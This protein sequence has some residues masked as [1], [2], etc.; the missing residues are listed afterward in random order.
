MNLGVFKALYLHVR[1]D[2]RLLQFGVSFKKFVNV[3]SLK[4]LPLV[5]LY[6]FI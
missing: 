4:A 5:P 6:A 2:V 3:Q 1:P